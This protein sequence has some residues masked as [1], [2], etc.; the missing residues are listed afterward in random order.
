M[1]TEVWLV[2]RFTVVLSVL[3]S[4]IS[5][6][7]MPAVA[8]D[9]A[10]SQTSSDQDEGVESFAHQGETEEVAIQLTSAIAQSGLNQPATTVEDW[11]AQIEASLVQITGVRVEETD[12]GLQVILET[13]E[14][15]LEV[16]ETRSLGNALI[17]DI[18]NATIAQEFSQAN[19]IEGI[20]LISVSQLPD[21]RVRV[22][23][24]GTEFP[25]VAEVTS[26]T[27]G[28]VLAVMLGDAVVGTEEDAIQVVV[29]GEQDEGYNPS[30]T[31][32]GTRTDTP[33]RDIP[34][35]IQVIPEQVLEDRQVRRITE[36]L[37]NTA[38]VIS[39]T[40]AT[41]DR[42]YF[43]VRGFENYTGFLING[44]PDPQIPNDGS[45]A[46]VERLEVL[47][48]PASVLYGE[49][50]SLGGT[51]NIVTRQPLSDPFYEIT[52]TVG[53]YDNYEGIF[54]LSGPLNDAETVLYR[55]IGS[56]RS[57]DS[58]VDFDDGNETFIAPSLAL[59]LGSNT[60]F[61]LEGDVNFSARQGQGPGG[62]PAVGTV[63]SNPNGEIDR[64]FNAAGPQD[65]NEVTNGRVGYRLEHRFNEN[66]RLR[67]AFRY[68]FTDNNDVLI[69]FGTGFADDNR[70]V[71][72]RF[73][74]GDQ[75]YDT[76]YLDTNVVGSFRTGSIDHQL[77]FGFSLDRDE[78]DVAFEFGDAAPVDVFDQ[79]F[80]Q[81]IP[82]TGNLSLDRFRTRDTL[83]I[84]LQD[85]ITIL[86]NLKLLLGGR[87]DSFEETTDNRLADEET[88]QSD[89]AFSPRVGIVYQPIPPISL[90]ASYARSFVPTIGI[91]ADGDTFRP[92]RGTQY[93]VGIRAD[94]TDQFSTNLALY[95]LTRSNVTTP[96][97][98]NPVLSVQ[99]GRQRSRGVELDIGGEIL[100]GWNIIGG[101]AYTDA[102]ITEDNDP[103]IEG[104]QRFSVPE[105]AFNLWTTYRIQNGDLQ[106]LGFGLGFYYIG[107]RWADNA[108]TVELPSFLRTDAAIYYERDR[109]RAAL[110]FRNIFDIESFVGD[111]SGSIL[112]Q[113]APF[114]VLGTISWQF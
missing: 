105:H 42:D 1:T 48:G 38:G 27:Q 65:N 76:Y 49:T 79:D 73:S 83:G 5:G 35:S 20:A 66:W 109:F 23:I 12:T 84:Y 102:R 9:F 104:N 110:N 8:Q 69:R 74:A 107:E 93:E 114:T 113:G 62:I 40:G 18:S 41:S 92:E 44:I 4:V 37:E 112:T 99:T 14:G 36:G 58:F 51:I 88:S 72:R 55:L 60:D 39:I 33:L 11:I 22:A 32:V 45:F 26:G 101:Y 25:P 61:I 10:P 111:G 7:L 31:S 52:A 77:L 16:P 108:N 94:I 56:Y 80:D 100:P 19:P 3:S 90:Y 24:T 98:N 68:T 29:T 54:D 21:N 34:Q 53:S 89:T 64:S 95:D 67:N 78:S 13:A 82:L 97:P 91:A 81:A 59:N 103:T 87:L 2:M 50:D 15:S 75:N 96:D 85:Q 70:T 43:T 28:L 57:F 63:L 6:V 106:G 30:N 17:A 46:N 47:R 71:N 86:E